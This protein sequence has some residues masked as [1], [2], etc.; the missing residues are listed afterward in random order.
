MMADTPL[1]FNLWHKDRQTKT[2]QEPPKERPLLGLA[3]SD[4]SVIESAIVMVKF[5]KSGAGMSRRTM[6]NL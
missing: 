6:S 4:K 5:L 1:P 2:Q 3:Y